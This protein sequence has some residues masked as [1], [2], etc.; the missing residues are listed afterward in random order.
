MKE[1]ELFL[2]NVPLFRSL[3][4]KD[5]TR[6]AETTRIVELKKGRVLFRK[7]QEGESL[8]VIYRGRIK[9]VLPSRLGDEMIL[10]VFS[11]GD[12][13]GEMAV[14]DGMPRSAD[15]VAMEDSEL[16]VLDRT[17]FMQ[18]LKNNDTAL[19][20]IL[21]SLSTRLRK[22]DDLLEDTCFL[23]ISARFAKRLVDLAENYGRRS[24][25]SI[26]INLDVTQSDLARMVGATRESINKEL[27][28]LREKGLVSTI[29]SKVTIFNLALL[30]RRIH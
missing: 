1:R 10:S 8:F 20:A 30:K 24:G 5:S 6:L 22:T 23:N 9:I 27:R 12:F 28:V 17:A 26:L 7:G 18:F 21:C 15:A 29:G 14:L 16:I 19:D 3:D 25:D 13:F 2:R 4:S 11:E